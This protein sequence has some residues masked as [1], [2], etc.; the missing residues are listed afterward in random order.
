M[1]RTLGR[2]LDGKIH[3][4]ERGHDPLA[5][6]ADHD[7]RPGIDRAGGLQHPLHHRTAADGVQYLGEFALHSLALA[8]GHDYCMYFHGSIYL[9]LSTHN[10]PGRAGQSRIVR[11]EVVRMIGC[12]PCREGIPA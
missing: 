3:V 2:I 4:R 8:G 9:S 12:S 7:D 5:L 6:M 10:K 11:D 1:S